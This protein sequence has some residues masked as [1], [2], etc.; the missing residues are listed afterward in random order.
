MVFTCGLSWTIWTVVFSRA[1]EEITN[2][3]SCLMSLMK[4][5]HSS[6]STNVLTVLTTCRNFV[7]ELRQSSFV[8]SI[9]P[10]SQT[11]WKFWTIRA[12]GVG[13][14]LMLDDA[15]VDFVFVA[16]MHVV[17]QVKMLLF[18]ANVEMFFFWLFFL[19]SHQCST[20]FCCLYWHTQ[21]TKLARRNSLPMK[22]RQISEEKMKKPFWSINLFQK[23]ENNMRKVY[24]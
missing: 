4:S 6:T 9:F 18:I 19:F 1:P 5:I 2:A 11:R 23:D 15:V 20:R 14:S 13:R 16:M 21:K 3:L 22:E 7:M 24:Y 10:S 12:F 17:E 8:S